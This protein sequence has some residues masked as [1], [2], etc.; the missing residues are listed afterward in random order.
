[1]LAWLAVLGILMLFTL[2]LTWIAVIPGLTAKSVDGA[3]VL[4][5]A[6]LPAVHQLGIRHRDHARPVRA[7]SPSTSR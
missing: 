7:S 6:H 3:S 5:P 1:M 2:A 4:L